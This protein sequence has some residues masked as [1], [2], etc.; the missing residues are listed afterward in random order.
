MAREIPDNRPA[1]ERQVDHV[2]N[3]VRVNVLSSQIR[4]NVLCARV[5]IEENRLLAFHT[6][7]YSEIVRRDQSRVKPSRLPPRPQPR[8]RR[9]TGE[10]FNRTAYNRSSRMP[11]SFHSLIHLAQRSSLLARRDGWGS[12][13]ESNCC[14]TVEPT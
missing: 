4:G 7:T 14:G 6:T 10:A 11:A 1:F 13:R 5:V 2:H 8:S 9:M 3:G 12:L